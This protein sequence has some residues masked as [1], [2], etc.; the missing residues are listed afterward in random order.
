MCNRGK[1]GNLEVYEKFLI[2]AY[3]KEVVDELKNQ[4]HEIWSPTVME[5]QNMLTDIKKENRELE[6][7]HWPPL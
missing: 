1:G 3:G 5:L 7:Q 6:S 4:K 2:S